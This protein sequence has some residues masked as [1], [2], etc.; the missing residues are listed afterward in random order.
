MDDIIEE[1]ERQERLDQ[2]AQAALTGILAHPDSVT[3]SFAANAKAAYDAAQAMM[4]ERE[5][6]IS[7]N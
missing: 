4:A 5:E 2:F 3:R 7:R 6:R 1:V